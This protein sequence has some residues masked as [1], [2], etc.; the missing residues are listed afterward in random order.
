[1]A[2]KIEP[3]A[4]WIMAV[5]GFETKATQVAIVPALW[6]LVEARPMS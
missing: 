2:F 5:R 3:V 6:H 4:Q 1:M